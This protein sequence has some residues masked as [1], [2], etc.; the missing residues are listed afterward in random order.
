ME[1]RSQSTYWIRAIPVEDL[2][3]VTI[4]EAFADVQCVSTLDAAVETGAARAATVSAGGRI[5]A[6]RFEQVQCCGEWWESSPK[7][8]KGQESVDDGEAHSG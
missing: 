3:I 6:T 8:C 2:F 1:L 4:I 5:R 7:V